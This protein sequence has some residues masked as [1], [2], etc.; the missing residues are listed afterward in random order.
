M[1]ENDD[2][3]SDKQCILAYFFLR[4]QRFSLFSGHPSCWGWP[5]PGFLDLN[6]KQ[7]KPK[8]WVWIVRHCV[9]P[10]HCLNCVLDAHS[11]RRQVLCPDSSAGFLVQRVL[12][13]CCVLPAVQVLCPDS[14][15][16]SL[17]QEG[18]NKCCVL[19]AG[20]VPRFFAR[21]SGPNGC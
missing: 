13:K 2:S 14:S 8:L 21:I 19:S 3:T 17:V 5:A 15:P 11:T 20:S 4:R 10:R 6:K 18:I 1:Q 7:N 12:T 16:G 9:T